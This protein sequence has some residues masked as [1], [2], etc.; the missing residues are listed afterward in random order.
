MGWLT[1][2]VKGATSWM[3][4]IRLSAEQECSLLC[5]VQTGS[6][7][8]S[9]SYPTTTDKAAVKKADIS[10]PISATVKKT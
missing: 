1:I 2:I 5:P 9:A 8:H 6:E 10:P 3:V 4:Q 7:A